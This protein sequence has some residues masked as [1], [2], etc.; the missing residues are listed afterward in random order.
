MQ[1]IVLAI[2]GLAGA[3]GGHQRALEVPGKLVLDLAQP[4]DLAG[5]LRGG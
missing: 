1:K 5:R 4:G 2:V 3:A